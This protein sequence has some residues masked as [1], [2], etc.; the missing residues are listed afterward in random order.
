MQNIQLINDVD[1]IEDFSKIA[2]NLTTRD[3]EDY[4]EYMCGKARES[5]D[6]NLF[7]QCP[8]QATKDGISK[9]FDF[10]VST[11]ET[12]LAMTYTGYHNDQ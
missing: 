10:S 11:Q 5:P 12:G 9:I 4:L 1:F 7:I 8:S 2:T 3:A 6:S